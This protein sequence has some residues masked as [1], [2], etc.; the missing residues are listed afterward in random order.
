TMDT[1]I[2]QQVAMDEALVLTAQRLK[3]GRNFVYQFEHKN[4][5][6][7]NDM[8]YPRFIKAIIHHF[9]SKDPLIP[10]RNNVNWHYVRDDHIFSTIK[11]VSRHQNT[12]QFGALLPIKLTNAE[13][14]NSK[15]YKERTR[16]SSDTSITPPTAA[17]SLR[18]TASIKGK[19]TA[20]A[21]K[22]KSLSALSEVAMT[23]A[24]QMKL[25]TKQSMQQTHIS[26]PSGSGADEGTDDD[27]DDDEEGGDGEHE[28]DE[29]TR[30]EESFDPN[31]QTPK[32]SEDEGDGE[33]D[34]DLNISEEE[35]HVEEEEE[36][37]LYRDVNINQGRGIQATLAVEDSH[38]TLTL[39]HPD[40][41][42]SIFGTTSQMD[43][44]TPT[45]VASLPITAPT[46]TSSTIATTT[47]TTTSQA[48]ILP[49]TV[50]ST[51]I[52]NLPNFGSLF[53]FDD[54]LRS[55]EENF[56]EFRQTN[57]FAGAVSSIPRIVNHYIDQRMNE[58]VKVVVQI[59]SDRLRDE[60]QRENDE[61]LRTIDEN[62]KKIIKEQVKEQVKALV[63]AYESEKL[64]LDTYGETVT[65]K[66]RRDDDVDKDEEPSA[67]PDRGSKRRREG[68]EPE[69][70]SASES[71]LA[72]EPMQ[73][74][75]QME[76][77]S[78]LEFDTELLAGP[79]YELMKGSCKSLIELEYHLE[80]VYKAT[81]DQLDW[82]NPKGQRYPHNL[83]QPLPLI[84][85]N[86]GRRVILF[87]HFINNDLE[88]LREGAS[89]RKYTTSIT[90]TKASNYGH[91]KWIEDLVPRTMWIQETIGYDKHA[92]WGVSH[93]GCKRQQFYGF[94]VNRESARDVYS[95]R[96]IIAVTE[97]KI[98]EWHSYKH[99]DWI[100]VRRDDDK[101][102]KFKEGDF[103]K[104][105]IQDI[106]DMLLLLVQGKLTNLTV[107]E[108]FA[109]DVSF[110]MFTRSIVIQRR[111]KDLQLGVKSYQ[112][113][114]NL[115][116]PDSY[117]SNLKHK[118]AYTAYSNPRGF[119]Y[120]NK[121]KRNRLMRIDELHKFSD[122]TLTD[123][124]T[125]LDYRRKGIRMQYL[126]QSIWRKSDKDR[127]AAMIQAIDKRLKTRRIMRSLE[128]VTNLEKDVKELKDV[129]NSAKVI[130]TIKSKVP[131]AI[132]EHLGSSLDDALHK[133]RALYHALMESILEDEDAM[134]E[135]V[136]DKLKKR[137]PDN[138]DKDEGP[139]TR[140]DRGLK[141]RK[142]SKDT[143]PLKK[144]KSS[145]S[146][147]GASKSQPKSTSKSAQAEET[148]FVAGDTQGP[149]NLREDIG[150]K[151]LFKLSKP[152]P[153]I[154]DRGL[155]VVP[156]DYF[157]NNDLK[158]LRGGSS[159]K[160]YMTSIT[161]TKAF[162]VWSSVGDVRPECLWL[163]YIKHL[164][165]AF[166]SQLK[167]FHPLKND[168]TSGNLKMEVK[169]TRRNLNFNGK[170]PV[171]FDKTRVEC[172][173]YHKRGHFAKECRAPRN[174]G[175]RSGDNER[176]VIPVETSAS[177]LVV[178]D[179]LGGYD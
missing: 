73:T 116:K 152:L 41:M 99:L 2:D 20:K 11:L 13:I 90:K 91:I 119:I 38:V 77:P 74:T 16:S 25:V 178:Q 138:A 131:N 161:K 169:K 133:Q 95:K 129:D 84:P 136:A 43:V 128:R 6:K 55:L 126:P 145:E 151:Y 179:G 171:G 87:E 18:L 44:Q 48:P 33:E 59:Q 67:G 114:L 155:Q 111:V 166:D 135:G 122:E 163:G 165:V 150:N 36:D 160:K 175:N 12:Q 173:N 15:A 146:S 65:L 79:T 147:K 168:N 5:K 177:A 40:G 139:S 162:N 104:L 174:Q 53:R 66:R 49:T 89:S 64:I 62:I 154:M 76:E 93:W 118:E 100:T 153:L 121:D 88:Y 50:P 32:D 157:I 19:Q 71:A 35:R 86:R 46:M 54:R 106:E 52:Q 109:F 134:H 7:S 56:F 9:M 78:H 130:S 170:E 23:E 98:V 68:K 107:E 45:S 125:A 42:E 39:V 127:A 141:R 123:V 144:A 96:R 26:Q 117:R 58:A 60:T 124:R 30:D 167:V 137:K 3:I 28:S 85:N 92:L 17:A 120:Q 101:L 81:T 82:V 164:L 105:R 103:K 31:P 51:I 143:K 159:S 102:Y 110:R 97:L 172:Y 140:S 94:P 70:A 115:T 156:V 83:L 24:Q 29:E 63:E 113:K 8:Y 75:S 1:T 176:R 72:E 34:L 14:R 4:Q 142:T 47:T 158:Y 148:V 57:Q 10:R 22:A 132:K 80:E 112:K 69:S 61:F 149:H 21:S 27:K 37:E 108:H